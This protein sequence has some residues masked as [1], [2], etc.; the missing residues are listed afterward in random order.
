MTLPAGVTLAEGAGGL[1]VVRVES[2]AATAVVHLQGAHVLE[3][4]PRGHGPVLFHSRASRFE[5]GV[6][7]R[8]GIPVCFPWFGGHASGAGPAHGFARVSRWRLTGAE[9]RGED[10]A[11][12]LGL[13]DDE[14]T[15]SGP[16]PHR[17]AAELEVVVGQRLGITLAVTNLGDAELTYEAALHTY[18]RVADVGRVRVTGLAGLP[19][20]DKAAG[21]ERVGPGAEP[22]LVRGEVDRVY[23]GAGEPVVVHD[24]GRRVVVTTD[25]ARGTVLWN[26]GPDRAAALPDLADDEWPEMLCVEAADVGQGAVTLAP[27]ETGRTVTVLTVEPGGPGDRRAPSLT[28]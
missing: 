9:R 23:L 15:R 25:G 11:L 13:G 22:T 7:I 14:T 19:Y 3:W 24:D 26:P 8:G 4:A 20:L 17:F 6:A 27:G 12:R 1:P 10:V 5:P 21:G 28:R 16:W 2:P 18:L